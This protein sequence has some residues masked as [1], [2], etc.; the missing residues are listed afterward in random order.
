MSGSRL[1]FD[2]LRRR[3]AIGA[4]ILAGAWLVWMV[5]PAVP[6]L[7]EPRARPS[8][9]QAG[10]ELFVHEWQPGD[11]L[12]HGDGLGPVFNA[13]SCVACHFQGGVGGGGGLK[14]DVVAYEAL[15]ELDRPVRRGLDRQAFAAGDHAVPHEAIVQGNRI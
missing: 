11:P 5:A 12:A 13:K 3:V 4:G 1:T 2:R 6:V 14:E 15:P 8:V 7:T 10:L 9:R